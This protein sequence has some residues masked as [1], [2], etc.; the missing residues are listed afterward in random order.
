MPAVVS[1]VIVSMGMRLFVVIVVPLR[2]ASFM[3]LARV[4]CMLSHV[5]GEGVVVEVEVGMEKAQRST[6]WVPCVF[7]IFRDWPFWR[8]VEAEC[9]KGMV[10][11][12]ILCATVCGGFGEAGCDSVTDKEGF[13]LNLLRGNWA[14]FVVGI[15]QENERRE[16]PLISSK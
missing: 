4:W 16:I 10:W 12:D 5:K 15:D 6:T 2:G 9:W 7:V 11:G 14:D 13:G 8:A 1:S 3:V